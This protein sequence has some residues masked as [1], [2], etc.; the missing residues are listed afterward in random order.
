MTPSQGC[1]RPGGF[2][3]LPGAAHYAASKAA[4]EQLARGWALEPA[5]DGI[6]VNALAPGPAQSQALTAAG[7]P[8]TVV[9]QIKR[10]EAACPLG[11]SRWSDSVR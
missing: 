10:E 2:L 11:R 6:R 8:E 1:H 5:G 7:L 9:Q 4:L 3:P